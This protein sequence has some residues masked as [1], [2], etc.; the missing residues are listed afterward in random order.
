[1]IVSESVSDPSETVIVMSKLPGPWASV[2]VQVNT[3][4]A[5]MAAPAGAPAPSEKVRGWAGRL[6][7]VA[8]AVNVSSAPSSTVLSPIAPSSG[9]TFISVT[10]TV[11]VSESVAVP[12]LTT[13]VMSCGPVCPAVGVQL[14][15]PPAVIVAPA[16][17]PAPSEYVSVFAGRSAS[18]ALAVNASSLPAATVLSPMGP[19][20]G[21][22]F[23]SVTV[24]MKVS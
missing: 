7:S 16:G 12:S 21:A 5:V 8:L 19:S 14:K 1:M 18:V 10:V 20:T 13:T 3:P 11:I 9:A 23:T 24:T 22:T 2:G 6:A 4:P 17:A 15:A